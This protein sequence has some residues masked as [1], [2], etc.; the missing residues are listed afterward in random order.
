MYNVKDIQFV[1]K[2]DY[3]KVSAEL[4]ASWGGKS[5]SVNIFKW[6]IK[7]NGKQMKPLKGVVRVHG[8]P[9]DKEKVFAFCEEVI[10][11][12]DNNIWDGRKS[13]NVNW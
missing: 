4:F 11:D 2:H 5:F 12:L 9:K 1:G 7:A 8:N 13:V 6:G 3:D 10:K